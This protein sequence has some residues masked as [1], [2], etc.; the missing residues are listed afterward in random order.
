MQLRFEAQDT[1]MFPAGNG[2]KR[3]GFTLIEMLVVIAIIAI[4]AALLLS[5]LSKAKGK[6]YRTQCLNNIRQLAV[7]WQLYTDDNNGNLVPNGYGLPGHFGPQTNKL[8]VQGD[9]HNY[10]E[11]FTNVSYL[12]DDHYSAFADYVRA[13]AIYKC[14]ADRSLVSIGG[15]Q[16]PR[17]RNYA[18]N[19]YFGWQFG[20]S[21]NNPYFQTF[22]KS[23]D[24]GLLRSSELYTFM[25][26]SPVN[27][28]YPAFFLA[29]AG[30]TMG[31][32][33][34]HRPSVEHDNSGTV[35]FADGHVE[36]HKW[37]D[38]K[39]IEYSRIGKTTSNTPDDASDGA[40]LLMIPFESPDLQWLYQHASVLK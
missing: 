32:Q 26:T 36:V 38:P 1:C 24:F 11:A 23:A 8:W 25:D 13:A 9:E 10:R 5:S 35:A 7:T 29:Y 2:R 4:L 40:H 27:I 22:K 12:I 33:M 30:T 18:L 17:V 34:F 20:T 16:S 31:H 19:S 39:T 28:C 15:E 6:A 21:R 3:G 14:P 37:R